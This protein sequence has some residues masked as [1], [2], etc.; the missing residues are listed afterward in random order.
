M[1]EPIKC[2]VCGVGHLERR[3]YS[4]MGSTLAVAGWIGGAAALL[5]LGTASWTYIK[6][7]D[8]TGAAAQVR[9]AMITAEVAVGVVLALPSLVLARQQ[10]GLCCDNCSSITPTNGRGV[11]R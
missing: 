1:R 9:N 10:E 3:Q 5:A 4:V 8:L 6:C 11:L 2:K 7:F